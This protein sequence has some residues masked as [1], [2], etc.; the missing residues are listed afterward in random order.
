MASLSGCGC[1]SHSSPSWRRNS[2]NL[3]GRDASRR[4]PEELGASL[5][6][7]LHQSSPSLGPGRGGAGVRGTRA[8]SRGGSSGDLSAVLFGARWATVGRAGRRGGGLGTPAPGSVGDDSPPKPCQHSA[9]P[10]K[11]LEPPH[12]PAPG[13]GPSSQG[14]SGGSSRS[15]GR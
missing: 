1:S 11:A 5:A 10:P 14:S 13:A 3:L 4:A 6:E 2:W 9:P 8:R 7:P 15:L 12:L